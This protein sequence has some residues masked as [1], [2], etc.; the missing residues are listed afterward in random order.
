MKNLGNSAAGLTSGIGTARAD[1]L[2]A[3]FFA[4]KSCELRRDVQDG[5]RV[6]EH[7]ATRR[8][9]VQ[10]VVQFARGSHRDGTKEAQFHFAIAIARVLRS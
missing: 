6:L 5:A 1:R 7:P 9:R 8:P 3:N 10:I 4:I 2:F